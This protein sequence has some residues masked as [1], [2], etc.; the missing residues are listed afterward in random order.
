MYI[1]LVS[2]ITLQILTQS[3]KVKIAISSI[4]SEIN[5]IQID[6]VTTLEI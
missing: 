2:G 5:D 3:L 4:F 1:A 6:E